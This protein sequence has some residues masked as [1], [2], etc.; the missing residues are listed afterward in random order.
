M[1]GIGQVWILVAAPQQLDAQLFLQLQ[2]QADR[3]LRPPDPARD[4]GQRLALGCRRQGTQQVDADVPCG[5]SRRSVRSKDRVSPSP[6]GRRVDGID[7]IDRFR[8][9]DRIDIVMFTTTASLS[10]R[11]STHCS[12]CAGSA[13]I[14]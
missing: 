12:T 4:I 7:P 9:L 1:A 11:T 8:C 10:D 14:S 5:S 2:P 6:P 13:L 3:R